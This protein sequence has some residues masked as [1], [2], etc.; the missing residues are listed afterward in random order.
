MENGCFSADSEFKLKDSIYTSQTNYG[1]KD[2]KADRTAVISTLPL[3][4]LLLVWQE[5]K[6]TNHKN[7]TP[8]KRMEPWQIDGKETS[9]SEAGLQCW[10]ITSQQ[11]VCFS[12]HW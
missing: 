9:A 5:N 8:E 4:S 10:L 3:L 6:W 12:L 2:L 11:C 1:G 7:I